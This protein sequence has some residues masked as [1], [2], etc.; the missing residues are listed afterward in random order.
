MLNIYIYIL[1]EEIINPLKIFLDLFLILLKKI[2]ERQG[3]R[4]MFYLL[5]HP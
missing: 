1:A 4:D 5:V 3:Q 2:T